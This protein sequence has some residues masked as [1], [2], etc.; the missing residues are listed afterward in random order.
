MEVR[1]EVQW[2]AEEMEKVL[3]ENDWKGGWKDCS[4]SWMIIKLSEEVGE[5]ATL[6]VNNADTTEEVIK[7]AADVANV[8]MM[9]ADIAKNRPVCV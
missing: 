9:I 1:S 6:F 2:F 8:A 5:L 4:I 7:E 3:K